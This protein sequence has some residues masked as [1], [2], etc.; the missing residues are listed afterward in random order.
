MQAVISNIGSYFIGLINAI[1]S[2]IQS[3]IDTITNYYNALTHWITNIFN[4][5]KYFLLDLPL[6]IYEK[7]LAALGWLFSWVGESCTYCIDQASSLSLP[8]QIQTG[9]NALSPGVLYFLNMAGIQDCFKILTCGVVI[10]AG[11]KL[12]S[13]IKSI[14]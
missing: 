3:I 5:L 9:F 11:F 6:L 7:L 4:S 2:F 12:I 10:W 14:L 8:S 13:V 1:K